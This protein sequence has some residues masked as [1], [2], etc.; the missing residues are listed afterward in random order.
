MKFSR[1]VGS[2]IL[3][4]F[5]SA[6]AFADRQPGWDFGGELLYQ[7]SQDV[8]FEG[9][10]SASMDDDLGIALT[11][12]YRFNS[13]LELVFGLDWNTV[14]YDFEVVEDPTAP[15]PGTGFTGSGDL[16]SFTPRVGLNFN[17]LEGD[18]TPYLTGGVG[19][20][21]IDTNIPD[22]PAYTSCWWD[23]WYGY[24]C[25]TYQSTRSIDELMYNVGAGV[26]W[27]ISPEISLRFGYEKH[28]IDISEASSTPEFD[29]LKFGISA[30]Y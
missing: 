9:G 29:Q 27:D 17:I 12:G 8:N 10:S 25:G 28:W 18:I 5:C 11:F 19:W 4:A 3:G 21:F 24:W 30:S 14:D 13:R 20:A 26:R 23:P 22:S 7:D 2:F 1:L 15:G 6:S 16:E